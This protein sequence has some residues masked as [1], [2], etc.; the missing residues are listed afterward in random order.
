LTII[1][2]YTRMPQNVELGEWAQRS[3]SYVDWW[4]K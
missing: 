1:E 3:F 2:A 4:I